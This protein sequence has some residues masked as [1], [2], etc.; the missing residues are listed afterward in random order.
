MA[1][2][3]PHYAPDAAVLAE[4]YGFITASEV[5]EHLHEPGEVLDQLISI[6]KPGGLLGLMTGMVRD[7][8]AFAK[9]NYI[10]DLTHVCFFSRATFNW[11]ANRWALQV[12]FMDDRVILLRSG[13]KSS[14]YVS[15]PP[16]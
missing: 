13:F 5:L 12:I 15:I 1:V 7:R 16:V 6:L 11:I 2:Y 9:W 3:D 8:P 14:K 10:R 4:A